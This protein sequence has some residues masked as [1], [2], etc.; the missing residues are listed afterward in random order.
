MNYC[1]KAIILLLL[2]LVAVVGA[3]GDTVTMAKIESFHLS[4]QGQDGD[5][6]APQTHD[7]DPC[8]PELDALNG[9]LASIGTGLDCA[10]CVL[11]ILDGLDET[12]SCSTGRNALCAALDNACPCSS[13]ED[14]WE[15]LILGCA[16]VPD[17]GALTCSTEE[18]IESGEPADPTIPAPSGAGWRYSTSMLAWSLPAFALL[19]IF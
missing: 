17:C 13:C 5:L 12:T 2:A 6:L 14:E 9:C 4:L 16:V 7:D 15:A 19:G 3:A 18:A 8:Q 1:F 11:T 10:D